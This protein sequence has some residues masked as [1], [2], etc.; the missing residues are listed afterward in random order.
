MPTAVVTGAAGFIGSTLV[1]RLL[2][3]GWTVVGVDCF[4]SYYTRERKE[5]NLEEARKNHDFT[6]VEAD[7]RS[8]HLPALLNR[9]DV[10]WHIA[11]QAGVRGSWREGFAEYDTHNVL[12]TQR[13]LEAASVAEVGRF[14]YAS[15]SSV[16][17]NK[18]RY[19]ASERDLP[20]PHSPYGVTKLAAEHLCRLYTSNFG[21]H[22][23]ILRYFTVY[24]PRQRPD[25][26]IYRLFASVL[27]GDE[28]P[29]Y[30]DGSQVRDF[31]Y[32]D[33]VVDGTVRAGTIPDLEAGIVANV[34]GGS[35]VSVEQLVEMVQEIGGRPIKMSTNA[36]QAGD[37]VRTGGATDTISAAMG[38]QP[39]IELREGLRRQLAWQRQLP[40][41]GQ[42]A[43]RSCPQ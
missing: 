17:G 31:T 23:A 22:T 11:A 16:Y 41:Y 20:E 7:L 42:Q 9:V 33:D 30:G 14:V 24:G 37:V 36:W 4:T 38:W 5:A 8:A 15:S 3:D 32:V 1:D 18:S 35:A 2:A 19:P 21:L 34:A 28:F 43:P 40:Q 26:A 27:G 10:V 13:L 39:A 29:L 25:M 12:A 6:L